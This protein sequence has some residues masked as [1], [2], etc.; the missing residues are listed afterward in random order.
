METLKKIQTVADVFDNPVRFIT[1]REA[2]FT[3][4]EFKKQCEDNNIVHTPGA[5]GVARGNGQYERINRTV[6]ETLSKLSSDDPKMRG[7][8]LLHLYSSY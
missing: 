6:K 4:N 8:N 1:D 5:A 7:S 2:A 3:S